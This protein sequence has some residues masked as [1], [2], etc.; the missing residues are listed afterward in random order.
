MMD[1]KGTILWRFDLVESGYG[2]VEI[3][4]NT[5]APGTYVY[6]LIIGDNKHRFEEDGNRVER[7]T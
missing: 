3:D 5:F 7:E 1:M 6:E 2:Q 4:A